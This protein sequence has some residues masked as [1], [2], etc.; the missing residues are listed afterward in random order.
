MPEPRPWILTEASWPE[1]LDHA[2][3]VA[4]LP[5]GA[6]EA[7]NRH[8][9]YGTDV[10]ECDHVAA[11]AGRRAWEAG[12]R[13]AILPTV[14]FGVNSGQL[15]IPMTLHIGPETQT[16]ILVDL[17]AGMEAHGVRKFVILNG[18]GGNDFRS[19][20]RSLQAT[21][22]AVFVTV[23]N[24]YK[25]VDDRA[26]FDEPGDHAGELETS[27]MMHIEPHLVRPLEVAGP[28]T[29]RTVRLAAHREGWAWA[30]RHWPSA[31]DDTGVGNP[32]ASTA[33]KGAR[34]FEAITQRI[35]VYLVDLARADL[36][37]LYG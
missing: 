31:T 24:W 17:V 26:Y 30:P 2:Y 3:E 21:F 29:G 25:V 37:D 28:G 14:P 35:G 7:H 20:V 1:V 16:A 12:A 36:D 10:Y 11:E 23:V 9:P 18:H 13:V 34:Y 6:T 19:I 32:G 8:L 27:L 33:A 5:W 15:S 4:V 22:P